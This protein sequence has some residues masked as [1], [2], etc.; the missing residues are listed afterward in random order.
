MVLL[1]SVS[2]VLTP[3]AV[4]LL[5][6][7]DL[8]RGDRRGDRRARMARIWI[9]I[10]R[11][12]WIEIAGTVGCLA[13]I[14]WYV[15]RRRA[16]GWM[17]ACYRLEYWWVRKHLAGVAR[18]AN[19]HVE[20]DN[21]E[22]LDGGNVILACRH[23]SHVDALVPALA[24]ELSGNRVRYTLKRDLRVVPTLDL[25]GDRT[26]NAWIDRSPEPGSKM[27]DRVREL[28]RGIRAGEVAVIF[29]ESTFFTPRRLERAIE[30]LAASRPDLAIKAA[31]LVHLLPPRPAGISALLAEAPTADV[32]IGANVGLEYGGSLAAIAAGIPTRVTIRVHMW[33]YPRSEVP[34]DNDEFGS[35][36]LDRWIKMD[37]WIDEQIVAHRSV[38]EST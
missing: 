30:R 15:R 18:W 7:I 38:A 25:L 29:P 37:R 34:E 27:L 24:A 31:E 16:P 13:V 11:A 23:V 9:L 3:V 2:T 32:V 36:L 14:G 19:I 22:V 1:A 21:V 28:G 35:W 6:L 8:L 17:R 12:A 10:V 33:R 26:P 5:Y 4:P 20:F